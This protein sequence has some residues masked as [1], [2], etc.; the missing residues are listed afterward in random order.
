MGGSENKGH[1]DLSFRSSDES[2]GQIRNHQAYSRTLM[3]NI[4]TVKSNHLN[5]VMVLNFKRI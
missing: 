3:S 2:L 5:T 1:S 4:G